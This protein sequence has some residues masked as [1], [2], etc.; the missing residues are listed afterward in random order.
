MTYLVYIHK[1]N[2][3]F[4]R[5]YLVERVP[6]IREATLSGGLVVEIMCTKA[7]ADDL[8]ANPPKWARANITLQ[9]A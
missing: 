2:E 4:A 9:T 5:R 3:A 8:T 1:G 7:F 6:I